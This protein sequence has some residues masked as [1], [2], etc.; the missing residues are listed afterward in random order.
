MKML[1][2]F[3]DIFLLKNAVHKSNIWDEFKKFKSNSL[4]GNSIVK[5]VFPIFRISLAKSFIL[6]EASREIVSLTSTF[7]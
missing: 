7:L 6:K 4:A 5:V 1:N 2:I 3:A